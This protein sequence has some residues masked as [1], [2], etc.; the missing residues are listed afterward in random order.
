[1]LGKV[2][3]LELSQSHSVQ[4]YDLG[5]KGRDSE[6][7]DEGNVVNDRG[8]SHKE[9]RFQDNHVPAYANPA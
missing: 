3:I 6:Q 5:L 1:M 2:D 8:R 9:Y 4:V 7:I